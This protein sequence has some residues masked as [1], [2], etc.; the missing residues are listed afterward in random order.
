[1]PVKMTTHLL[2][3]PLRIKIKQQRAANDVLLTMNAKLREENA[4]LQTRVQ[5]LSRISNKMSRTIELMRGMLARQSARILSL[6][7]QVAVGDV[8]AIEAAARREEF[9]Q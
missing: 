1:M 5:N 4:D 2:L 7:K 3:E 8:D 6:E 9:H